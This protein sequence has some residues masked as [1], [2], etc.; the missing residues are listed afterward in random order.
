MD[1][2]GATYLAFI[3]IR[4]WQSSGQV[5]NMYYNKGEVLRSE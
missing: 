3:L 2:V 1:K 5:S 4:C